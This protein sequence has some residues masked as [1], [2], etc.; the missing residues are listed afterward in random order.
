MQSRLHAKR[1]S[2][3][4]KSSS[5]TLVERRCEPCE[6]TTGSLDY[7]GLCMAL[8]K[9]EAQQLLSQGEVEG[10]ELHEDEK[11]RL[12]IRKHWRT[13]NFVKALDLCKR[14]GNVAEAE[15]HHPDL[16]VTGWNH[17]VVDVWTHARDGLTE[18]DFILAAKLNKLPKE[19]LLRKPKKK[20]MDTY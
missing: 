17:V 5:G 11:S 12:H 6:P 19:D 8:S 2:T 7:M 16:H 13:K 3:G 15:D 20:M 9:Q 10:W 1:V 18:N 14:L 4:C